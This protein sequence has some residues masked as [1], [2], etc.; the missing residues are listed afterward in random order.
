MK[1]IYLLIVFFI[2]LQLSAQCDLTLIDNSSW[3]VIYTDSEWSADY[4]GDFAIDNDTA[5]LWHTGSGVPYPHEIQIDLGASYP[6]SGIGILPRQAPTN[7]KVEQIEIYLSLDGTTW[8]VQGGE[9]FFYADENDIALRQS[10][11]HS[12][13][14]RYVKIVGLT[15]YSDDFM[16]IA[17]LEV[18]QDLVC[19]PTG[20]NNQLITFEEILD[21]GTEDE[22]FEVNA[23]ASSGLSVDYEI[24]SGP[25]TVVGNIVTLTGDPGIVEIKAIQEGDVDFYPSEATVFFE[26]IDLSLYYP[27]VTTRLIDV[28]PLE[29]PNL[30]AYPIYINSSIV[31]SDDLVELQQI[32][33]EIG[34]DTFTAEE[35][36]GF[37]YYLWTPS[38]YGIHTIDIHAIASNGNE[39][40]ITRNVDV[41]DT[42]TSQIV[43]T[44]QDVVIEFGGENSRWYYGTYTLP[45]FV[46]AYDN[47]DAFFEVECPSIS[48]GCDD[49]DRWAHIDIKGPDGNWIQII[50]YI[51]PYGV[52]CNHE[53]DV[54]DYMS[55]LQGEV[56]FRVFIDTWGTGGWQLTLN[57][58]YN[59]GTPDYDYSNV[60]EIWDA[61]YNFGDPSNLQPVE[62]Y[63]LGL[64]NDIE[65]SHLRL[66]NT[67]HGWGENNTGNAAEFFNAYHF[68]DVDSEQTFIQ[69]LWNDCNPNPDNCTGQQGTWQYDRAGWCPGAI[70]PPDI[71]D[72]T[73]YIGTNINLAYRF[74]P[75]YQDFCHP[76]N[77]DCVS[78]VT[79]VDCNAGYNPH[80]VV[81]G[82]VIKK[83]NEPI[84][85]GEVLG[86]NSVNNDKV[87][88]LSVYPNPTDGIFSLYTDQLEGN[89]RVSIYTIEGKQVKVYYF[90]SNEELNNYKFDLSN[91]NSGMYFINLEN[92][93]GTGAKKIILE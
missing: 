2:S 19:S 60:V 92:K 81:D 25:A 21:K 64:M 73:P 18:Y 55:L 61:T 89:T 47:I 30:K 26:V 41:T 62:P 48:G 63:N 28:Y 50:R 52:A 54:T 20:Q 6:L 76:N 66:S 34:N 70:S 56:E 44:L 79:C 85:Y 57:L 31:V 16:G 17:E 59:Q 15:G 37:Y 82:Q 35:Q 39:T 72:L 46:G 53:L 74:H 71:F 75:T 12:I 42:N 51:T 93:M 4:Q 49:W 69:H 27:E 8:D 87:F 43:G 83:S 88:E 22:P 23:Y 14:A 86:V 24:V 5:T 77:P 68:I 91:L 40:V 9:M 84:I 10:T 32:D 78:G 58:D 45:Q 80:Y 11:F 7:A 65:E 3:S 38:S 13:D 33:L 67:G 1:K 90:D 36:D 29:M